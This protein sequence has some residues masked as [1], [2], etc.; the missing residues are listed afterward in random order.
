MA[1][2]KILPIIAISISLLNVAYILY[3]AITGH[4]PMFLLN[5]FP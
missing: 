5:L 3:Y 4:P 1:S 2:E